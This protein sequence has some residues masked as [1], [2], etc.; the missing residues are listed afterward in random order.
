MLGYLQE[1][2]DGFPFQITS[3]R[4]S[5]PAAPYPFEKDKDANLLNS[6]EIKMFIMSL[7]RS[8]GLLYGFSL[9]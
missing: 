3:K 8:H 9:T 2:V 5:T 1:I 7:L 4:V 6:D